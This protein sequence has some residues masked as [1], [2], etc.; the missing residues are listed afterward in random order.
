ML[1]KELDGALEV[2][3]PRAIVL[4]RN[5]LRIGR[6]WEVVIQDLLPEA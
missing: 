5:I 3:H 4:R 6:F 1:Q 2:V